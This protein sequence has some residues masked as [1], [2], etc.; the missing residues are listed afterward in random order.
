MRCKISLFAGSLAVISILLAAAPACKAFASLDD[1][2]PSAQSIAA[3]ELKAS[4]AAPKEQC[5]LYAELV[6]EM[7]E[8]SS[9]EYAAG[10]YEQG[11]DTLKHVN[12]FAQKIHILVTDNEKRLKNAQILLRHTA[13]RLNELLHSTSMEDHPLIEKTLAQVNQVQ[14][15]AMLQVFRK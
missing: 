12:E 2:I 7:I 15:E 14:N 11:A 13:F 10:N 1:K 9:A 6:H 3:L 4:Q 8:Y 5:F